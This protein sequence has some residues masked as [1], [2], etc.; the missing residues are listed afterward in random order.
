[1]GSVGVFGEKEMESLSLSV[2]NGILDLQI[3]STERTHP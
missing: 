1:M 3:P 2:L